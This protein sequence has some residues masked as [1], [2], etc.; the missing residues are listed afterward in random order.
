MFLQNAYQDKLGWHTTCPECMS[1]FDLNQD[2]IEFIEEKVFD[3]H[4]FT[5]NQ[6]IQLLSFLRVKSFNLSHA[7]LSFISTEFYGGNGI[8]VHESEDG[9]GLIADVYKK[10]SDELL[11]SKIYFY[12]DYIQ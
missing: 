12:D 2:G 8:Y 5:H 10:D 7:V 11:D 3:E 6:W 9:V 4:K 1:S